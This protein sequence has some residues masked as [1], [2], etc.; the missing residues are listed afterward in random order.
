MLT[1]VKIVLNRFNS[2]KFAKVQLFIY[3]TLR[4]DNKPEKMQRGENCID[5]YS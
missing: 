2:S 1:F 5:V 3:V 4:T